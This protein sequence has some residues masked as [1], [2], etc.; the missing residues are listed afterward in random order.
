MKIRGAGSA[1]NK[2]SPGMTWNGK[3]SLAAQIRA[4][5]SDHF[6]IHRFL[7]SKAKREPRYPPALTLSTDLRSS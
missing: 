7:A 2:F 5:N 3:N 6:G 4:H 1:T